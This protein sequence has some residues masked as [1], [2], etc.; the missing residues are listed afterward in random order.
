MNTDF[1]VI[2][3]M[4]RNP[5]K[6]S[7]ETTVQACAKIF[8]ESN[9]GSA[10]VMKDEKLVG[11]VT[12]HDIVCK[13]VAK[14]F[15]ATTVIVEDILCSNVT[16]IKPEANLFDAISTMAQLDIRHLPV[17][18]EHG[19]FMGFLTSKDVLKIEPALFEIL[20]DEYE[21][22]EQERKPIAGQ[23]ITDPLDY[24]VPDEE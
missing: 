15:D 1:K 20:L 8:T 19:D 21:L 17:V 12:S 22:R 9:V 16:T 7:P 14:G 10:L 24:D 5:I 18:D 11:I 3:A 4:T 6:V 2:D 13:C 23:E